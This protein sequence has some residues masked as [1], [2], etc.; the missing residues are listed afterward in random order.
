M[1]VWRIPALVTA[2]LSITACASLEVVREYDPDRDFTAYRTYD[3]MPPES[4]RIDLRT[5]DPM[6]QESLR[7]GIEAELRTKGFRRVASG[8]DPDLRI[9]YLFVLEDEVDSQTMYVTSAPDWSYRTYGP[10]TLETRLTTFTT[11]A[12]I[13]DLF[14]EKEKALVWRGAVEGQ[15]DQT[16]DPEKRRARLTEA[17]RKIFADFPPG[18]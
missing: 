8:D 14:D 16:Q 18:G 9:G 10:A 5:R 6:A 11:G 3:W 12:L 7:D 2:V 1:M 15:V 13:I 17:I 4:R